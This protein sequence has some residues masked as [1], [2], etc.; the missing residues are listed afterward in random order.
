[1]WF[2]EAKRNSHLEAMKITPLPGVFGVCIGVWW[3]HQRGVKLNPP[4]GATALSL[5][6]SAFIFGFVGYQYKYTSMM[7]ELMR[8]KKSDILSAK[9][10]TIRKALETN[11]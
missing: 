3:A 9:E 6:A 2:E 4:G 8:G 10:E 5:L 1:M 11:S 7:N